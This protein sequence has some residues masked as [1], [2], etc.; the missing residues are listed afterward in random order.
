MTPV[1]S[2]RESG[3]ETVANAAPETG[4]DRLNEQG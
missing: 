1:T 3:A 4:E 2:I